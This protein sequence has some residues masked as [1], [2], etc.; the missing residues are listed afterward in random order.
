MMEMAALR[1]LS[2]PFSGVRR[3]AGR[4]LRG[5]FSLAH[6]Y[7]FNFILPL[8]PLSFVLEFVTLVRRAGGSFSSTEEFLF[9][10][11]PFIA[12][13]LF[14]P[15][16][17][18]GLW[19]SAGRAIREGR[20]WAY[21]ARG[22]VAVTMTAFIAVTAFTGAALALPEFRLGRLTVDAAVHGYALFTRHHIASLGG[23]ITP[24]AVAQLRTLLNGHIDVLALGNAGGALPTALELAKM[25]HSRG[26]TVYASGNCGPA[27]ALVLVAAPRRVVREGTRITIGRIGHIA[28]APLRDQITHYYRNAGAD[29]ALLAGLEANGKGPLRLPLR[30]LAAM[31]IVTDV[32]VR[33][34]GMMPA[35]R[36][37]A[38][39]GRDCTSS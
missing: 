16:S 29:P 32:V 3:Y 14:M 19:R 37:C 25:V 34:H 4:H 6:A 38:A 35:A 18:I 28:N 10:G 1:I 11:M 12:L 33:H 36:W 13:F 24:R 26:I 22:M 5:E 30:Q 39:P 9:V 8:L 2:A 7:W 17:L 31:G 21:F 20:R 27:C 23:Q 15:W